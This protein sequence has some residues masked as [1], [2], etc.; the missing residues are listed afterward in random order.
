MDHTDI[1]PD[2]WY[3]T[4]KAKKAKSA[5]GPDGWAR[6]DLLRMPLSITKSLLRLLH[7]IELGQPW[8]KSIITGIIH[9]LE[10]VQEAERVTQYRPITIF[11]LIYRTYTSIRAKQLLRH[12]TT[13]VPCS[14]YGNVPNRS[15]TQVWLGIQ[16]ELEAANDNGQVIVGATVDVIKCFNHLPRYPIMATLHHLGAS[17]QILTAWTA[18]LQHMERRFQIRGSTGPGLRSTTGCAEGCAL[19][20]VGM[21]AINVIIDMWLSKKVPQA[22]LYTYV[23]M[24]VSAHSHE[25]TTRALA[26]LHNVTQALDLHLDQ[27]KTVLWSNDAP[28]RKALRDSQHRVIPWARDLGG[29]VQYTAQITNCVITERIQKFKPRWK[30]FARSLAP[31]HQKIKAIKMV[32]WPNVLHGIASVHLSE[33]HHD[34]LRTQAMRGLGIHNPGTSPIVHLSLVEHPQTDPG[35]YAIWKTFLDLRSYLPEEHCQPVLHTRCQDHQHVRPRPGPSSVLLNRAH[36]LGWHWDNEMIDHLGYPIDIWNSPIQDLLARAVQA[37]QFRAKGLVQHRKTMVDLTKTSPLL[38]IKD[39]PSDPSEQGLLRTA[40]NGTFYTNERQH[41]VANEKGSECVFCGAEDS[42]YHRHWECKVLESARASCPADIREAIPSLPI[43]TTAHGWIPIPHT[44][45]AFRQALALVPDTSSQHEVVSADEPVLDLFTDGT[46]LAPTEPMARLAAWGVVQAVSLSDET[47]KPV[48]NGVLPGFVQTITRA[49]LQAAKA[50]LLYAKTQQKPF[51][52]WIDSALVVKHLRRAYTTPAWETIMPSNKTPNHDL[53]GD[54]IMLMGQLRHRC[55][56]VVKVSSHQNIAEANDDMERWTWLG[57]EA[58]DTCASQ[59]LAINLPVVALHHQLVKELQQMH[60]LRKHLHGAMLAVGRLAIQISKQQVQSLDDQEMA[61]PAAQVHMTEWALPDPLP[62]EAEYYWTED[63]PA[64]HAWLRNL[65]DSSK[66][67]R[68]WSWHQL[69]VSLRMWSEAGPWYDDR[70]K[71]WKPAANCPT[72]DYRKGLRSFKTYMNRLAQA[73]QGR[74]PVQFARPDSHAILY[75]CETV[76]VCVSDEHAAAVDHWF[77][78]WRP[79]YVKP[80]A[81][82]AILALPRPEV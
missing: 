4:L 46:C 15:A 73:C 50:A 33:D 77:L 6:Q 78:S 75:W 38:T 80:K 20:V 45:H 63:W 16:A 10:K 56:A 27:A 76:T 12:L 57:N 61:V 59:A 32:A 26:E 47:F 82:E 81:L 58:A 74:V 17:Q 2:E 72:H 11:S 24:E 49:E 1:T 68:R 62:P 53:V 7:K 36:Q 8:P 55:L 51:R 44:Y 43:S 23:D 31:Y 28:T 35:F 48:A 70:V 5:V 18:A 60:R 9:S 79:G 52:L 30:D 64:M 42:Q 65:H 66:P 19:S 21:L 41:H 54:V 13:Q 25:V 40:L 37:W 22:T 29:H 34:Q 3:A 14:C 69:F 39:W 67:T 71:S